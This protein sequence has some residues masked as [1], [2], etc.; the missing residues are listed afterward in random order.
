MPHDR[1]F[2]LAFDF[3]N[4]ISRFDGW[5]GE[6]TEPGPP[7]P[8]WVNTVNR[9]HQL[10]IGIVIWT[11]RDNVELIA[12]WCKKHGIHYDTINENHPAVT[13]P[14]SRKIFA[15]MYVDDRAFGVAQNAT[16]DGVYEAVVQRKEEWEDGKFF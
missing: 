11:C 10:G 3:D 15:D 14:T 2:I 7:N 8:G 6:Y 13:W 4:T 16:A 1:P 9:C 12:D 5:T